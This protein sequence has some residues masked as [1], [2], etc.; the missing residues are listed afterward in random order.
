MSPRE[1]KR[2]LRHVYG[3]RYADPEQAFQSQNMLVQTGAHRLT[4][5]RLK[6]AAERIRI[7]VRPTTSKPPQRAIDTTKKRATP[8][9]PTNN[10]IEVTGWHNRQPIIKSRPQHFPRPLPMGFGRRAA[11]LTGFPPIPHVVRGETMH[12]VVVKHP[13]A[14]FVEG[15]RLLRCYAHVAEHLVACG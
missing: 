1:S 5:A 9:W 8:T 6:R 12:R 2:H 7:I 11:G 3:S 14:V 4:S 10:E 15:I 13:D